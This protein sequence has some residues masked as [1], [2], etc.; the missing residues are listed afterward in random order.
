MEAAR[1]RCVALCSSFPVRSVVSYGTAGFRC[2]ALRDRRLHGVVVRAAMV[3]C[4]RALSYA[5]AAQATD[6]EEAEIHDSRVVGVMITASHNPPS[7]NGLKMVERDGTMLEDEWEHVA[8]TICN[9]D[10]GARVWELLVDAWRNSEEA[11]RRNLSGKGL[12][13]AAEEAMLEASQDVTLLVGRD[14]RLSGL[15][16]E[17]IVSQGASVFKGCNVVKLGL[18]TTP[19]LHFNVYAKNRTAQHRTSQFRENDYNYYHRIATGYIELLE[20]NTICNKNVA[21]SAIHIDCAHG[22]GTI[23]AHELKKYIP[24]DTVEFV[25]RNVCWARGDAGDSQRPVMY[26]DK[27]I[28]DVN[29]NVECGA[30]YVQKEVRVPSGFLESCA[31][32]TDMMN[33]EG[34]SERMSLCCSMDGDADRIVFF[35]THKLANGQRAISL[36]DGDRIAILASSILN[37]ML[38]PLIMLF[39]KENKHI[40]V[41]VIQTAYANGAST[42]YIK[43]G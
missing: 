31:I 22:I 23:A 12:C 26:K 10:D 37:D 4:V 34:K 11:R 15:D 5:A 2:D 8:E 14:T 13:A 7:D 39:R 33:C 24:E 35:E 21:G 9:S 25:L 41:G 3:S 42:R 40:S 27:S 32:D 38:T 43:V 28:D 29:L 30:D 16:L 6:K 18:V 19:I 17:S 1:E 20:R 36:F